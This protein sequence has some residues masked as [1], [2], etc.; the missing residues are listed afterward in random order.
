MKQEHEFFAGDAAPWREAAQPGTEEKVLSRDPD[1][2][3]VLTRLVRWLPGLDTSAAGVITHDY[4]EEVYLLEGDL[5]DLT[6]GQTFG[7]GHYASRRPGMRHGPYRTPAGCT[8]LE[9][10]YRA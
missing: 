1:D 8:M 10:R 2:P 9:I 7:P 5:V 3:A 4:V 6:L